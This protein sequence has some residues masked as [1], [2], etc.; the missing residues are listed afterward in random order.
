MGILCSPGAAKMV[1]RAKKISDRFL[2]VDFNSASTSLNHSAL[3]VSVISC[4]APTNCAEARIREAFF[5]TL[6]DASQ[7]H[8]YIILLFA[9]VI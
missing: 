2:R 4:Y 6:T 9:E 7:I 8:L 5:R 1:R 3:P